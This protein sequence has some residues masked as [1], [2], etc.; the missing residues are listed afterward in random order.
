MIRLV[1]IGRREK[2]QVDKYHNIL[3]GDGVRKKES[4]SNFVTWEIVCLSC[5][6]LF[7]FKGDS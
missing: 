5:F 4:D 2:R 7:V 1:Q 6:L 3:C